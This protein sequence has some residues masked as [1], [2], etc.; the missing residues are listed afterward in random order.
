MTMAYDDEEYRRRRYR[1]HPGPFDAWRLGTEREPLRVMNL[2]L[3]GCFILGTSDLGFVETFQMQIDLGDEGLVDVSVT[4]LYHTPD[5]SGVTFINLNPH[6]L[7]QIQRT[8]D[9]SWAP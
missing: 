9:A 6:A 5:G 1:R 7:G 8:V 2:N 4:T 3:G